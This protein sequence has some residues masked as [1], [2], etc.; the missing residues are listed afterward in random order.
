MFPR[1]APNSWAHAIHGLNFSSS[2]DYKCV[3]QCICVCVAESLNQGFAHGQQM[4]LG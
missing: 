4:L 2:L 3:Y 1:L